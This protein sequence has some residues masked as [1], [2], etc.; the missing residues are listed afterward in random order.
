LQDLLDAQCSPEKLA[1][2]EAHLKACS[3][4]RGQLDQ[5]AGGPDAGRWRDL[6]AVTE[7]VPGPP[8]TS[9]LT[10]L[11]DR[12]EPFPAGPSDGAPGR[13][14][15]HKVSRITGGGQ[16]EIWLA[17]DE[18]L[19]RE[20]VLKELRGE[21]ADHGGVQARFVAEAEITGR[22]E[23]PGIV[24]VYGLGR[25]A[26]G[27]PFYAT[28]YIQGESLADALRR[29]HQAGDLAGRR[30]ELRRLLG[31]FLQVCETV[32]FAHS[33]GVVHRD[34]KPEN[35]MLGPYGE[36]FVIDWGLA[37]PA[38]REG[39]G[40]E[41]AR[42]A[43]P[44]ARPE[45]LPGSVSG[46]PQYMSPEQADGDVSRIG[47]ASDVYG[48][49]ATLY[50]LLTGR[51]PFTGPNAQTVLRDVRVG[52]FLPPRRV[53]GSVP[54]ALEA[55]C[56]KAMALRSEDRYPSAQ[57]LA[58]DLERWLGDEPMLA[59]RDG[60]V[61]RLW[62]WGRRHKALAAGITTALA[63]TVAALIAWR[64]I[65]T[66]R[67]QAQEM[68]RLRDEAEAQRE[69]A[70]RYQYA[71][72]LNLA[73]RFWRENQLERMHDLLAQYKP[74]PGDQEPRAGF[75]W[76][77]LWR[78]GHA[79]T[80]TLKYHRRKG[81]VVCVAFSPD[82][83]LLASGGDETVQLWDAH[84]G[85]PVRV[86]SL[87][88]EV[89]SLGF[90]RDGRR[91]AASDRET[92]KVWDATTGKEVRTLP[93]IS[94]VKA[95]S[96]D[97]ARMAAAEDTQVVIR[98]VES[99]Q[100]RVVLRG[101]AN[102]VSC[103][104]FSPDGKRLASGSERALTRPG[105]LKVWDAV[106]GKELLPV[107]GQAAGLTA[108]A[109]SPDG[110][111]L[112]AAWWSDPARVAVLDAESG[113]E[114]H[115]F[116]GHTGPVLGLAFSPDG[117]RLASAS[118]DG[119]VRVWNL[120]HGRDALAFK[121]HTRRVRCVA[122]SPDGEHLASGSDDLTVKL[123]DVQRAQESYLLTEGDG[124]YSWCLAFSPDGRRLAACAGREVTVWG[125]ASG[126]RLFSLK[127][128]DQEV[129]GVAFSPDGRR[130]ASGSVD[131]TVKVW[132][133]ANGREVLTLTGHEFPVWGVA[134]SPDGRQFAAVDVTEIRLWD[135]ATGAPVRA[136][137]K[138]EGDYTSGLAFSPDGKLLAAA[139]AFPACVRLW[140]SATGREVHV[141][142]GHTGSVTSV[143][144]SPA[145]RYLASASRDGSVK[146]W[147]TAAGQEVRT[148]RGHNDEVNAVTFSPDGRR[149]ASGSDDRTVKV[150]DVETGRQLLTLTGHESGV[151]GV[152]FSPDGKRLASSDKSGAIRLWEAEEDEALR[153]A[154]RR[155]GN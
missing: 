119:T 104:A 82:G 4:C 58:D 71:A 63:I 74:R 25:Y 128:H 56:L 116:R 142:R 18:E 3:A 155:G 11:I 8:T 145:A 17:L 48:L 108:V 90:S 99:G 100:Q 13:V 59:Y 46:T 101:H 7:T 113:E 86:L 39:D 28:R 37:K 98:D 93:G 52:A 5:M 51:P 139:T 33:R 149:L 72:D 57:A 67:D 38:A 20:V 151:L 69:V 130:L 53:R 79:E 6:A 87:P 127:G 10:R 9:F 97:A 83:A 88:H 114:R 105:E 66:A 14:R 34:L 112:A 65:A 50:C 117:K 84:T 146:L 12:I 102:K 44:L 153:E 131:R 27:R 73:Q 16:G 26:D 36:T 115:S 129:R 61:T 85:Q 124:N 30:L 35:V 154:R 134:F 140:D 2:L 136:L 70:R 137:G 121:G 109:F 141:L 120:R 138:G 103:L 106:T 143:A 1:W 89:E 95:F 60:L 147:D 31:R 23:H 15:F 132:D 148:L 133:V 135:A 78:L 152:A 81:Q 76:H 150:W 110:R 126:R 122:F 94:G 123:W 42:L 91:L 40:A 47:P 92:V 118:E 21:R 41:S 49:G 75:E 43:A 80:H 45:T 22:L 68:A 24:P 107:P 111:R 62:R 32:A 55:V 29:F 54:R 19:H 144:F 77:Y 64:E 125:P 96:P